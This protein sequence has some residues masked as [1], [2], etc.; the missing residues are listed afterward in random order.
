MAKFF[1]DATISN[2]CFSNVH[3]L[4]L[5]LFVDGEHWR[6]HFGQA[7]NYVAGAWVKQEKLEVAVWDLFTA[8]E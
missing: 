6:A 7:F 1:T 3:K 2:Y 4:D 5:F 8:L